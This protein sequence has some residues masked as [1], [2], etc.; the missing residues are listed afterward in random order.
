VD[1]ALTT[2]H[3]EPGRRPLNKRE[4]R[5][6]PTLPSCPSHL[7]PVA[8]REWR[9]TTPLLHGCGLLTETDRAALAV[10]C[11]PWARWLRQGSGA[12]LL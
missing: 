4:P 7:N 9:R 11:Q 1:N 10:Y 3:G 12:A 6:R 2:N 8:R 5:P